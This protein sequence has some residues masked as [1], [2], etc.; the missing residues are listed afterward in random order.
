MNNSELCKYYLEKTSTIKTIPETTYQNIFATLDRCFDNQWT[1]EL[2]DE[3]FYADGSSVSTTVTLYI[4]GRVLT[5][6]ATCKLKDY[7]DNHKQALYNACSSIIKTSQPYQAISP[8]ED[9]E[10]EKSKNMTTEEIMQALNQY[11]PSDS[12]NQ[13]IQTPITPFPELGNAEVIPEITPATQTPIMDNTP[14][15]QLQPT[16]SQPNNLQTAQEPTDKIYGDDEPQPK[17]KGFSKNQFDRVNQ[18][19]ADFDVLNDSMFANYVKT[20][21]KELVNGKND[22]KPHNVDAFLEWVDSLGKMD[23]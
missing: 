11:G 4:P 6:R 16:N 19:K 18:F 13:T 21:N 8:L 22:I 5:G 7:P 9:S 20:W 17:Y 15:Q 10:M 12:Q 23:C 14:P 3:R 2:A 1:W